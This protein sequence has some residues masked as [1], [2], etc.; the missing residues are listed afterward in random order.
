M[1]TVKKKKKK[2]PTQFIKI[3]PCNKYTSQSLMSKLNIS[4]YVYI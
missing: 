1:Y 2:K 4:L 3:P